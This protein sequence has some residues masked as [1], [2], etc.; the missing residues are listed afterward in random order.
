MAWGMSFI[1]K[2]WLSLLRSVAIVALIVYLYRIIKRG[3]HRLLYIILVALVLTGAIGNM[4][5]FD[6]LWSDVHG[7]LAYYVSYMV[8]SA[9]DMR[10]FYG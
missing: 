3:T 4:I 1:G 7:F 8:R 10:L 9:M 2:F 6:V 5:R